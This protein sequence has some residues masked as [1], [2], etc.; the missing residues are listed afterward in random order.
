ML[1]LLLFFFLLS[2]HPLAKSFIL[3]FLFLLSC[4]LF[5]SLQSSALLAREFR[6][7]LDH[8]LPYIVR[9]AHSLFLLLLLPLLQLL[10]LLVLSEL[11]LVLLF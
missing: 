9:P 3:L 8:R 6:R 10:P 4:F 7:I 2:C 11:V 5:G 1:L